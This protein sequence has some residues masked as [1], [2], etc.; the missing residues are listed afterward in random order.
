MIIPSVISLGFG[1]FVILRFNPPLN[2]TQPIKPLYFEIMHTLYDD[3][4]QVRNNKYPHLLYVE[5]YELSNLD[6]QE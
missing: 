6:K 4:I 3:V 1:I 2:G 5:Q